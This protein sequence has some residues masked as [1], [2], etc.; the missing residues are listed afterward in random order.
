MTEVVASQVLF[1]DRPQ[2][3]GFPDMPGDI[4]PDDL[5]FA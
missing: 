3:A 4:E 5:P 2:G 1:L